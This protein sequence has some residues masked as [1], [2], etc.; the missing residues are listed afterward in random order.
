MGHN[1]RWLQDLPEV[2]CYCYAVLA[3][4]TQLQSHT[5]ATPAA[6]RPAASAPAQLVYPSQMACAFSKSI[7]Q[8]LCCLYLPPHRKSA[9]RVAV[10]Q[11]L[12]RPCGEPFPAL[13]LLLLFWDSS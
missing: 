8:V 11:Q 2:H 7:L 3:D 4:L 12:T 6:C 5:Y 10:A 9:V 1:T 13:L